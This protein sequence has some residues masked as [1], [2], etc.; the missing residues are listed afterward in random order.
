MKYLALC[1]CCIANFAGAE[2]AEYFSL[3]VG[4]DF[5]TWKPND[6][7][8]TRTETTGKNLLEVELDL[9]PTLKFLSPIKYWW[10]P[11]NR[12]EQQRLIEEEDNNSGFERLLAGLNW[13][14]EDEHSQPRGE[15]FVDYQT[16]TFSGKSV[17]EDEINYVAFKR[18]LKTLDP[19]EEILFITQFETLQAGLKVGSAGMFTIAYERIEYERPF[20]I[21]QGGRLLDDAIYDGKF[22]GEGLLFEFNLAPPRPQRKLFFLKLGAS[23]GYGDIKFG[24]N[25]SLNTNFGDYSGVGYCKAYAAGGIAFP[26]GDH[27]SFY[28]SA[29]LER[30]EFITTDTSNG[31]NKATCRSGDGL[32]I[33]QEE[34]QLYSIG[35]SASF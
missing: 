32:D 27:F 9:S 23:I 1:L 6:I 14:L 24:N 25:E 28:G 21:Y 5:A 29:S 17:I 26:L 33:S 4:Y 16:T 8:N 34:L 22:K 2:A 12:Q 18:S 20:N 3:D 7:K 30:V 11:G 10:T 13:M 19:G 15:L 31:G 35:L